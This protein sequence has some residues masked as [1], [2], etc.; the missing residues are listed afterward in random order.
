MIGFEPLPKPELE[1]AI[2]R[3]AN[4]PM[5]AGFP[6]NLNDPSFPENFAWNQAINKA[7]T[8][9][10]ML[11]QDMASKGPFVHEDFSFDSIDPLN[12]WPSKERRINKAF[13][14]IFKDGNISALEALPR[15]GK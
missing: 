13:W 10:E 14:D 12:P 4:G 6:W 7:I 15:K 2:L 5:I 8:E 3:A 11:P 9:Q 1:K